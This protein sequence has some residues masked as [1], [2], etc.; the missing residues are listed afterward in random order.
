[1]KKNTPPSTSFFRRCSPDYPLLFILLLC[2][3]LPVFSR[4][5]FP[6]HDSAQAFQVFHFFYSHFF[7]HGS[8]PAWNVYG[9]FGME[10]LYMQLTSL[11]P[12]SFFVMFPGKIFQVKNA[13]FLFYTSLFLERAVFLFGIY[14]LSRYLFKKRQTVFLVSASLVLSTILST[15]IWW[16][17]RIFYLFPFVIHHLFLFFEKEDPKHFWMAGIFGVFSLFGNLIYFSVLYFWLSLILVAVAGWYQKKVFF[18]LFDLKWQNLVLFFAFAGICIL[19][20]YMIHSFFAQMTICKTGRQ[21]GSAEVSLL[22]FQTYGGRIEPFSIIKMLF[23]GWP[24]FTEWSQYPD[25]SLYA[26]LVPLF[27]FG[28]S[29]FHIQDPRQKALLICLL[30]LV[31]LSAGGIFSRLVYHL[32]GFSLFRHIS[33]VFGPAKVFFLLCAGYAMDRFFTKGHP[34]ALIPFVLVVIFFFD[35]T[36]FIRPT[37]ISGVATEVQIAWYLILFR[38]LLLCILVLTFLVLFRKKPC[39]DRKMHCF[40]HGLIIFT[41]LDLMIFQYLFFS[42]YHPLPMGREDLLSP[43]E[44]R[45]PEL[46]RMRTQFPDALAEKALMLMTSL[47]QTNLESKVYAFA[48][49]EPVASRF[50]KD[51]EPK[52]VSQLF[53]VLETRGKIDESAHS[54]L[55]W[56][57]PKYRFQE[58]FV[59]AKSAYQVARMIQNRDDLEDI[60][61]LRGKPVISPSRKHPVSGSFNE[62]VLKKRVSHANEVAFLVNTSHSGFLVYADTYHPGWKAFLDGDPVPVYEA[63][64]AFKAVYVPKGQH[65]VRFRFFRGKAAN[66]WMV[67]ALSF[68]AFVALKAVWAFFAEPAKR[69]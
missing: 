64:L 12:F 37:G 5:H 46:A 1:M 56:N 29:L 53:S 26:G 28:F 21:T 57:H 67:L 23:F 38:I 31:W 48:G 20:L 19:Y 50:E 55:G 40:F 4:T 13:L 8:F 61:I 35:L 16:N 27:F 45:R 39:D 68:W 3:H 30:F 14:T 11:S 34:K 59:F 36:G 69:K 66:V 33:L 65:L 22:V 54:M 24:V 32:P 7:S 2:F 52:R 6:I 15:Q 49:F 9:G 18:R 58:N 41:I 17:F 25:I 42:N 51:M 47:P 44:V 43:V 10:T 62:V 63:N 60:V